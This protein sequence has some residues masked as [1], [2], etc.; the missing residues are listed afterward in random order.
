MLLEK[1]VEYDLYGNSISDDASDNDSNTPQSQH[2][3]PGD[4]IITMSSMCLGWQCRE[5]YRV[6]KLIQFYESN[7]KI[8][9][10][11][12]TTSRAD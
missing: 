12:L 5:K 2:Q 1:G 6:L 11:I 9:L 4:K 10:E 8:F 3:P 7:R